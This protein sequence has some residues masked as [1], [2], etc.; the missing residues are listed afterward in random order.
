MQVQ[1]F[2]RISNYTDKDGNE[3]SATNFFIECGDSLVPVE[4]K[5]FRNDEGQD[6]NYR[7]R[8]ALLSAFAELLPEK[9]KNT[10]KGESGEKNEVE[11]P[12]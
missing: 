10:E 8:K 2:K 9:S 3:K 4:V 1:V 11:N 7:T 12:N 5:Y 6:P